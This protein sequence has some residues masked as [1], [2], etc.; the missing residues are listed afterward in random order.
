MPG[1][2]RFGASAGFG[3]F[4]PG[5]MI[6]FAAEARVGYQF[7][8]MLGLY[9]TLGYNRGLWIGGSIQANSNGAKVTENIGFVGYV[10]LGAEGELLLGNHFFIAAGPKIAKGG[11]GFVGQSASA[12]S[13]GGGAEQ[14]AGIVDGWLPGVG[15]KLGVGFGRP[16][17]TTG[18]RSGFT[19]MLDTT[20]LYGSGGVRFAQSAGSNGSGATA[21]QI[22]AP[23][24]GWGIAPMLMFGFESR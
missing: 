6:N 4:V 23:L 24:S 16:D 13:G 7:T 12:G 10:Q 11:W 5:P 18:R 14:Y 22:V 21:S 2:I 17:P 9:G 3:T 1:R 20:F 19:M 8:D 15:T